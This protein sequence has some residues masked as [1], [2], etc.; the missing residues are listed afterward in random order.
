MSSRSRQSV[1]GNQIDAIKLQICQFLADKSVY[2]RNHVNPLVMPVTRRPPNDEQAKAFSSFDHCKI[3]Q[4][5][6]RA[7]ANRFCMLPMRNSGM[8]F[9][10]RVSLGEG[11]VSLDGMLAGRP[12]DHSAN[13]VRIG[14]QLAD[15]PAQGL[16]P[17]CDRAA[18]FSGA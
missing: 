9:P 5:G 15:R 12:A 11:A 10:S 6:R 16:S 13:R 3:L 2:D 4:G 17:I 7:P 18:S 8:K 1:F 14:R